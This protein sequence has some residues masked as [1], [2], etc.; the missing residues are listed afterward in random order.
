MLQAGE[1]SPNLWEQADTTA[2]TSQT[3]R[4]KPSTFTRHRISTEVLEQGQ[5]LEGVIDLLARYRDEWMNIS[6]EA[7]EKGHEW[8]W[9]L[10][11]HRPLRE[12]VSHAAV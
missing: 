6:S 1:G 8:A 4:H 9:L 2:G 11:T 10:A 5:S 3:A 7:R 12:G